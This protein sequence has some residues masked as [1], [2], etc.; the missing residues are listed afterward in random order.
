MERNSFKINCILNEWKQFIFSKIQ[1]TAYCIHC[2]KL[3]GSQ[4]L[5]T[6]ANSISDKKNRYSLKLYVYYYFR[7]WVERL[8]YWFYNDVCLIFY[9][10]VCVYD[11]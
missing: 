5:I 3:N 8:M 11:K 2:L 9:F 1:A 7:F 6:N 4:T 10:C